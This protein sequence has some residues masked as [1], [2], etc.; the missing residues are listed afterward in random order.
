VLDRCYDDHDPPPPWVVEDVLSRLTDVAADVRLV[1][2][3]FVARFLVAGHADAVRRL[4]DALERNERG[5]SLVV[6]DALRRHDTPLARAALEATASGDPDESVRRYAAGLVAGFAPGHSEWGSAPLPPMTLRSAT[7]ALSPSSASSSASSA[8][9]SASA[10]EP[11]R[12]R[13]VRVAGESG[14]D[15]VVPKDPSAGPTSS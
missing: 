3:S 12:P 2:A 10:R 9:S 13:R 1:A 7:P 15:V 11:P 4:E 6:C 8:A 14:G 5:L